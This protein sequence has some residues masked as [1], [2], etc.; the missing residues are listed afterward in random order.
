MTQD[1]LERIIGKAIRDDEFRSILLA[2]P[3]QAFSDYAIYRQLT[4][5]PSNCIGW[6]KNQ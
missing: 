2:N 5:P 3:E 1:I 4:Y 6:G